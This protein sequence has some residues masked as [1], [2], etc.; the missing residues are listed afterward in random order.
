MRRSMGLVALFL[1]LVGLVVP[2]ALAGHGHYRVGLHYGHHRPYYSSHYSWGVHYAGRPYAGF[3][4]WV[5]MSA[6]VVAPAGYRTYRPSSAAV[7][8]D[9][10]P[11]RA[12][13]RVDGQLVGQARDFN[14]PWDLLLL[15]PGVH[16][17]ELSA[18]GHMSLEIALDAERGG[19]YHIRE[20]LLKGSGKDPRSSENVPTVAGSPREPP[21][22]R[23]TA[24]RLHLHIEPADAAVYLDGEFLARAGELTRLHGALSV[25]L[26]EHTVEVTRPGYVNETRVLIVEPDEPT[27]FR[28][29][30]EHKE[31][32]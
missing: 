10:R 1:M 19:Y 6:Y 27:H 29:V 7:E 30:L 22:G 18:P 17:L 5:P 25:A 31:K 20:S 32:P 9:V 13:V 24:G 15:R 16:M 12:Q 26:G 4:V 11:K 23:L 14:G 28:I 8:T 3:G 2:P 21:Q